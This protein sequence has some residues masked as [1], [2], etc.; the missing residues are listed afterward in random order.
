MATI[1]QAGFW[2]VLVR[3]F[4]VRTTQPHFPSSGQTV[5]EASLL[6][7]K[8]SL[9]EQIK[10]CIKRP[11]PHELLRS[12]NAPG[13]HQHGNELYDLEAVDAQGGR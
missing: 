2:L 5:A 9:E 11:Q 1:T 10:N 4:H 13:A 6:C 8:G 3:K 7:V 12:W